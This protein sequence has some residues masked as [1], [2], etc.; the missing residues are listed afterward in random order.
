MTPDKVK[1]VFAEY[2][3]HLDEEFP[4]IAACQMNESDTLVI[5]GNLEDEVVMAH[6]KFMCDKAIEFVA[7]G[8]MDKAMRWLGFLQG[9]LWSDN[10]FTLDE[11]KRHSMP[12]SG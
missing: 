3:R 5:A 12:S 6:Y 8:R 9:A 4:D 1:A 7:E 10:Q 11:L 2:R